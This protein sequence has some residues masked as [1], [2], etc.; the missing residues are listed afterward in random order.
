MTSVGYQE[1]DDLLLYGDAIAANGRS[2]QSS[3]DP[4]QRMLGLDHLHLASAVG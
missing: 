3:V 4:H 2:E 1:I